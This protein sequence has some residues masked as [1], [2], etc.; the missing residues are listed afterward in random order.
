[1]ITKTQAH[2]A[3]SALRRIV[4]DVSS[5]IPRDLKGDKYWH[6]TT[7]AHDRFVDAV[8]ACERVDSQYTRDEVRRTGAEW[9]D[10]WREAIAVWTEDQRKR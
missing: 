2:P 1:M 7:E 5:I 8:R 6:M 4:A 3:Q 9:K 10:S